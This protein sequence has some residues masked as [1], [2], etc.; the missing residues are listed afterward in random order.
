MEEEVWSMVKNSVDPCKLWQI[1]E[2]IVR[3]KQ[4]IIS[5][6]ANEF[7]KDILSQAVE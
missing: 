7:L 6:E 3:K 2:V 5:R 4:D 1:V